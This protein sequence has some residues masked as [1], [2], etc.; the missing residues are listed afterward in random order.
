MNDIK[1][2][3]FDIDGTLID[4]HTKNISEKMLETLIRLKENGNILCIATGRSPISLP[5]FDGVEFDAFLTFNGSY[6]FDKYHTILSNSIPADDVQTIIQNATAINRPVSLATRERLVANGK[7]K[8]LEEYFSFA[9][10]ELEVSDDFEEVTKEEIYQVM[11]GCVES[12]YPEIMKN[13]RRAKITAWWDRA[14]DIIPSDGGKGI[15]VEKILK[16]YNLDKAYA[17][18]F[19]DGNNDIEM[20]QAVGT[21]VAMENAS[22]RL[23]EIADDICGHVSKD[24]IY[25][26]CLAHGLI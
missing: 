15:A 12:E 2:I 4:M 20:L 21:G 10:L 25:H 14:V 18:A 7:E 5:H 22:H 19:G 3:F 13:V 26:Y 6:C 9:H 24:G 8:N 11:L 1:I 23:K 16:Y 17:L